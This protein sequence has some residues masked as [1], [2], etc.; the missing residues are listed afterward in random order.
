MTR[1]SFDRAIITAQS[2]YAMQVFGTTRNAIDLRALRSSTTGI[3]MRAAYAGIENQEM[4]NRTP[5]NPNPTNVRPFV[6]EVLRNDTD[7]PGFKQLLKAFST[8]EGRR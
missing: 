8:A 1:M 6:D 3:L 2:D 5:R 7:H 4:E